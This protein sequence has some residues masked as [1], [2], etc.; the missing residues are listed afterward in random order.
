MHERKPGEPV[1]WQQLR[2]DILNLGGSRRK[3]ARVEK[4]IAQEDSQTSSRP[5]FDGG[6]DLPPDP[7]FR[8][9]NM[10]VSPPPPPS[11]D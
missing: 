11:E 1:N 7:K 2:N 6:S 10:L 3:R 4:S 5:P 8:I 9:I